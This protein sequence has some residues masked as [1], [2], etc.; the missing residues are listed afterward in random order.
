VRVDA[1]RRTSAVETDMRTIKQAT[2]ALAQKNGLLVAGCQ[3]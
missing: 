1:D 2:C 3:P